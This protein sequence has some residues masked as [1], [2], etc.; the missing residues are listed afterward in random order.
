MSVDKGGQWQAGGV[1]AVQLQLP[2]PMHAPLPAVATHAAVRE[3]SAMPPPPCHPLPA[4]CCAHLV[5]ESKAQQH[6]H[7]AGHQLQLHRG[8]RLA[9]AAQPAGRARGHQHQAEKLPLALGQAEEEQGGQKQE[10]Y[11]SNTCG[12]RQVAV[13]GHPLGRGCRPGEEVRE[14]GLP[15]EEARAGGWREG[16]EQARPASVADCSTAE[17][18]AYLSC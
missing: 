2:V 10:G 13:R 8:S 18:R 14:G 17:P 12:C 15:G 9:A 3:P 5:D 6:A 4:R 1:H 7:Q 11:S 16:G